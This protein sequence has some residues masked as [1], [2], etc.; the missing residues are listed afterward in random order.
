MTGDSWLRDS[1]VRLKILSE[2]TE[3]GAV[4]HDRGVIVEANETFA[5]MFGYELEELL[6]SSGANLTSPATW[7][8]IISR[9]GSSAGT[10]FEG[11]GIRK[12][13]SQVHVKLV[14]KPYPFRGKRL[15]LTVFSD[16]SDRKEAEA[17]RQESEERYRLLFNSMLDG[18]LLAEIIRDEKGSVAD[19]RVIEVNPSFEALTGTTSRELTGQTLKELLAKTEEPWLDLLDAVVSRGKAVRVERFASALEKHLEILAFS[20]EEGRIA[21]LVTDVTERK[22]LEKRLRQTA[23]LEA[24]GALAS[25]VAHEINNP[26][27]VIMNYASLMQRAEIPR[28]NIKTY[29][30]EIVNESERVASI[31]RNLLAFSRQELDL[32]VPMEINELVEATIALTRKILLNDQISLQIVLEEDLPQVLC[33]P[34]Q[35]EQALVNLVT[36]ARQALGEKYK[37]FDDRKILNIRTVI[38]EEADATWVRT[39]VEDHGNGVSEE[40]RKRLFDPFYS[41][42]KGAGGSG[43]GLTVCQGIVE[44]HKGRMLFESKKG[45]PTRFHLDLPPYHQDD[46]E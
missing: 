28:E 27:N 32:L 10:P 31:V 38:V 5:R 39:T 42:R 9:T 13:G 20:H 34:R 3:E 16:I 36:N 35:I 6:G 25:G 21:A 37:G 44:D 30:G 33:R 46:H 26:V 15:G 14:C 1:Q 41:T 17:Q 19:Y 24:I 29:A 43:L 7:T 40:A 23:K 22:Q 11:I 12:N 45:G 4:V 18:F 2:V 8:E